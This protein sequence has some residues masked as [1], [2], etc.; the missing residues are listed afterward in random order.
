MPGLD[1]NG[2]GRDDVFWRNTNNGYVTNWLGQPDGGFVSND[3]NAWHD[4]PNYWVI[5]PN[6]SG[7]GLWDY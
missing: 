5:Q 3:A 7:F 4:V 1:F 6:S 2:D